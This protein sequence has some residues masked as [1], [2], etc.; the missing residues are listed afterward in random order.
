VPLT[1]IQIQETAR[2]QVSLSFLMSAIIEPTPSQAVRSE[3][4]KT[5][6]LYWNRELPYAQLE[7]RLAVSGLPPKFMDDGMW[8]YLNE[9]DIN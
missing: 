6:T 5:F 9:E 8:L 7:E 4:M 1:E 3:V 2:R